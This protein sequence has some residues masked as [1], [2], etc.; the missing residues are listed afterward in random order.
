MLLF[1]C[2]YTVLQRKEEL[3]QRSTIKKKRKKVLLII[4]LKNDMQKMLHK[5]KGSSIFFNSQY[6]HAW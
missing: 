6:Q 3:A 1:S 2:K 5:I 4:K